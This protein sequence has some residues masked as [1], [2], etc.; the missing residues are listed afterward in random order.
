M[1]YA[2]TLIRLHMFISSASELGASSPIRH[3][4]GYRGRKIDYNFKNFG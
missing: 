2:T 4:A 3:L 1:I